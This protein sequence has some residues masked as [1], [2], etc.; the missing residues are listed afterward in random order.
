MFVMLSLYV[1]HGNKTYSLSLPLSI[2]MELG[3]QD[4]LSG[5]FVQPR[6]HSESGTQ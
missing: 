2:N 6:C 3:L 4:E 5:S 1:L